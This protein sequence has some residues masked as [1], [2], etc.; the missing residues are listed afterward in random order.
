MSAMQIA[1]L[2]NLHQRLPAMAVG[3]GP[4]VTRRGSIASRD[5]SGT[6][7]ESLLALDRAMWPIDHQEKCLLE[8]LLFAR[9]K[10]YHLEIA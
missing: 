6:H 4:E 3:G 9:G 7:V 8:H 10:S 5:V 2:V 1:A